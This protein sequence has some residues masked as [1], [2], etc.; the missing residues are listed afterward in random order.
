[1]AVNNFNDPF[2][3]NLNV[4]FNSAVQKFSF[5]PSTSESVFTTNNVYNQ[6][7][8]NNTSNVVNNAS[9]AGNANNEPGIIN[10]PNSENTANNR[11]V[12]SNPNTENIIINGNVTGNI[13]TGDT[14]VNGNNTNNINTANT[15]NTTNNINNTGNVNTNT[16]NTTAGNISIANGNNANSVNNVNIGNGNTNN[17]N[18]GQGNSINNASPSVANQQPMLYAPPVARVAPYP[19]QGRYVPV[20]QSQ[21]PPIV[22]Y[23]SNNFLV[24]QIHQLLNILNGLRRP[25]IQQPVQQVTRQVRPVAPPVPTSPALVNRFQNMFNQMRQEIYNGLVKET[26][27]QLN[28]HIEQE[29]Y[30][31]AKA[32]AVNDFKGLVNNVST[33]V[34]SI[35]TP[36]KRQSLPPPPPPKTK[37]KPIVQVNIGKDGRGEWGDPHY[38][39]VAKN[40][41]R[42][43]FDHKGKDYHTYNIFSGDNLQIDGK[44]VPYKDPKNPQV[45][46]KIN[47]KAGKDNLEFTK[48]GE[49][50]LNG[51]ILKYGA[52]TLQDGTIIHSYKNKMY[53]IT[54]DTNSKVH[55]RAESSGITID[56]EGDFYNLDGIIGKTVNECRALSKEECE[57][58]DVTHIRKIN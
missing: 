43:K 40:G 21:A 17:V 50:H 30:H 23:Q 38:D 58:F 53:I 46:G 13:N 48:S 28:Q 19:V 44:Y 1:M 55:V 35:K 47:V 16:T 9:N 57:A 27:T 36:P 39:I 18:I 51:K 34:K 20:V 2:S 8:V 25:P 41:K 37:P 49:M 12:A 42:I 26:Y 14:V 15:A 45:V 10:S 11:N 56:P 4:N 33:A 6:S 7:P 32:A 29:I 3:N 5:G 24:G 54:P 31:K 52:H 22:N